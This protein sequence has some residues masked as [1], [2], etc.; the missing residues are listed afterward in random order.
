MYS[1]EIGYG[2]TH[3]GWHSA[4]VIVW[5]V[6]LGDN[7]NIS[8]HRPLIVVPENPIDIYSLLHQNAIHH[9]LNQYWPSSLTHIYVTRIQWVKT[10]WYRFLMLQ[11]PPYITRETYYHNT[12]CN[13]YSL[14]MVTGFI[15]LRRVPISQ[16]NADYTMAI[17]V[18]NQPGPQLL[19][20][21]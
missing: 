21:A 5:C 2:K 19:T 3:C 8:I 14:H 13:M 11:Q 16:Q 18:Y 20:Y 6:L 12:T 15:H 17:F 9:C 1:L 4:K 10:H 7:C